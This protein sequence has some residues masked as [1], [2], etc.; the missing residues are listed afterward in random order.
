MRRNLPVTGK[1]VMLGDGCTIVS[2]TNTKGVIE[3]INQDFLDISG[4]ATDELVDKAHNVIRHPDMPEA[5][6][7]DLWKDLKAERPWIGMVKNRCKNGDHYWV[8]SHF[9]PRYENGQLIGYMSVR[10]KATREA[11]ANAE[12]AYAAISQGNSGLGISHGK[13]VKS[14]RGS[15]ISRY[16]NLFFRRNS[17]QIVAQALML[18]ITAT[19]GFCAAKGILW[20]A[21]PG[22]VLLVVLGYGLGR[23]VRRRSKR[24]AALSTSVRSISEGNYHADIDILGDGAIANLARSIKTMQVRQGY[25]IQ[26][27]KEQSLRIRSALDHASTGM[28]LTNPQLE[29]VY[30]NDTLLDMLRPHISKRP[31]PRR[32]SPNVVRPSAGRLTV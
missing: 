28:Y 24:L 31:S 25:E 1:E 19:L 15:Y 13:V 2:K 5:A 9:A 6:F 20:P 29:I 7:A 4:F 14:A 32:Q 22:I 10:Q 17:T 3:E 23:E 8:E 18:A 16:L 30:A 26:Q 27:I 11:I 21:I 12:K